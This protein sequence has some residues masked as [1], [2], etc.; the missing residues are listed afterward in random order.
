[1]KYGY[2]NLGQIEAV[3]N[4]LGGMDGVNKFLR[5]EIIV[6][7]PLRRWRE[8]NGV[9]YFS[10]NSDGATGEEW[11]TRFESKGFRIGNYTKSVLHSKDFKPT[12][13]IIYEIAVLKGKF[14]SI[15]NRNTKAICQEAKNR[16]FST[17]NTEVACLIREKFS[18]KELEAMGLY[19]IVAMHEPIKDSD[20]Y[21]RLLSAIRDDGGSWLGSSYDNF[22]YKWDYGGFAFVVSQVSSF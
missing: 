2:L 5:D 21:P 6:S 1:M 16:K 15:S 11:I 3:V 4:K 18:D 17:P 14:F 22:V 19:W 8:E 12:N 20:G 9:I 13:G 10:V 7:E